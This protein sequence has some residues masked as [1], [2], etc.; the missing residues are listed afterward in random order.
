MIKFVHK[1][2]V[3]ILRDLDQVNG[4]KDIEVPRWVSSAYD[5]V[6]DLA[7]TKE[8]KFGKGCM[9]CK[10]RRSKEPTIPDLTCFAGELLFENIENI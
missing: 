9:R 3:R 6:D 5:M 8:R 1:S 4:T 2:R 7:K 10:Y